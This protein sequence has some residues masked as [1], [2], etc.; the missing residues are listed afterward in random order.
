M[1][2]AG[3]YTAAEVQSPSGFAVFFPALD[4][5]LDLLGG[6]GGARAEVGLEVGEGVAPH[7]FGEPAAVA[8]GRHAGVAAHV[9]PLALVVLFLALGGARMIVPLALD[10]KSTRLNSS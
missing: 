7:T 9:L 5:V 4:V 6:P 3:T 8:E 1:R 2:L 10:R